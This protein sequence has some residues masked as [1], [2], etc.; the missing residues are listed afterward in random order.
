MRKFCFKKFFTRAVMGA[1]CLAAL[2]IVTPAM[3]EEQTTEQTVPTPTPTPASAQ[4]VQNGWFTNKNGSKK[5]FRKGK[6]YTGRH[7]IQG[8]FYY[9]SPNNGCMKK[10]KW[11]TLNGKRYYFGEDGVGYIGLKKVRGKW[12]YFSE[13]GSQRKKKT[14]VDGITYYMNAAG[15]VEAYQ[16][17]G[18]FYTPEGKAMN[19]TSAANYESL[20][21]A[22]AI[23]DKITTPDM[24]KSTKLLTCFNWVIKHYYKTTH[25]Y[26]RQENWVSMFANDYLKG[27]MYGNCFSDACA[28]A[29]LAKAIGYENVYV[30]V[31]TPRV[32]EGHCFTE[33]D[34]LFYDPLFAEA[35][36]FNGNYAAPSG[37]YSLY[38]LY[39][40]AI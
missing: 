4:T 20:Q 36:G 3:A 24:S 30:C 35:K 39:K 12:Y 23:V 40:E 28:F 7:K 22:K 2:C 32:R 33:I 15:N 8:K 5:Y 14:T 26:L 16:K 13:F 37:V 9:F 38:P 25:V 17:D 29:F 6:Y 31:D 10:N 1:G 18:Q 19:T 11:V 21:Y 27:G 34:G